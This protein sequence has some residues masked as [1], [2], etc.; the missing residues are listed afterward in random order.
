MDLRDYLR[1]L[2]KG[3]PLILA[4]VVLGLAAGIG[5]TLATTKVYQAN[6]QVFVATTSNG[7]TSQLAGANT[8]TSPSW[9]A[10]S[11]PTHH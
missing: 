2:R 4:F 1:V 3:W 5:L 10:R 8:S 9:P 11:A 6:V 7:D